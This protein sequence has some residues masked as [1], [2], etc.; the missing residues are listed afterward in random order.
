M[1][2]ISPKLVRIAERAISIS[3]IDFGIPESGGVRTVEQQQQLY[4]SGASKADGIKALS[5]HQFGRAIDFYAYVDGKAS[6]KKDHLTEV[7][8]A[9]MQ[10]ASDLGIKVDWGGLWS[11][12]KDLPHIQLGSREEF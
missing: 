1:E 9:F 4:M 2:G 5:K 12:F 3:K 8:H 10:A 11:N 6:W 7:A